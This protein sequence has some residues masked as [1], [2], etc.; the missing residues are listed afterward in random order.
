MNALLPTLDFWGEP[1]LASLWRASWQGSLAIFVAWFVIHWCKFL[2]PRVT[3]WIWRFVCFKLI[4]ALFWIEPIAI[5]LLS[6]SSVPASPA[7]AVTTT[8]LHTN[9]PTT[10]AQAEAFDFPSQHSER[11]GRQQTLGSI[12]CALW[13][14]GGL[15]GC[16]VTARQWL[17]LRRLIHSATAPSSDELTVALREEASRLD[18]RRSPELRISLQV[19]SP[20]L[21]GI[22]RPTILLPASAQ[23]ASERPTLRIMLAH[24]IAHLKRHDLTWNWLP[25]AVGWLFFFHPLVWVMLR[26]WS[27]AQE[28]ACDELLIQRRVAT[29]ADYGR[30]LLHLTNR[31]KVEPHSTLVAAGVLGAYRNLERRILTMSYVRSTSPRRLALVACILAIAAVP[32]LVPWRLVAQESKAPA[33]VGATAAD[34][35]PLSGLIYADA[36]WETETAAGTTEE[37]RGIIAIDPNSGAFKNLGVQG[38]D[39]RVS[40]NRKKFLVQQPSNKE[41]ANRKY[42]H[43]DLYVAGLSD[44]KPVK[45]ADDAGSPVWSP[46]GESILYNV[47]NR[48]DEFGFLSSAWTIDLDSK[49]T[50]KIVVPETDEV[51]D[52]SSQ[53]N[54]LVTVSDRHPPFGHGYQL[55]VMHPDGTGERRLTEGKGLNCYPRFRPDGKQIVY[56]HQEKAIN[57][58]WVVDIDGTN[59]K[60]LLAED[61]AKARPDGACWSPDGKWLAVRK[62]DWQVDE[63]GKKHLGDSRK[64]N[65]RIA[66]HSADGKERCELAIQG[67]K[68]LIS[69]GF[70]DWQ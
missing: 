56:N 32:S 70:P 10:H 16:A 27:E 51:D 15:F 62:C 2:S 7:S 54:W 65:F 53:G 33:A 47:S 8:V 64:A 61:G 6:E 59:R 40:P 36:H 1:W 25:T 38:H 66:I 14:A 5:P 69:V 57:S 11:P 35:E 50:H 29:A 23:N 34:Q 43:Y 21:A 44:P 67:I 4:F 18:V 22:W 63:N 28:A 37:F 19:R 30:F 13:A 24:E 3:C 55:Y 12:L 31:Q 49:Q 39:C 9:T 60:Q 26:R 48:S 52:W 68:Q 17:T 20:L 45:L 46:D 58:L 41:R 42:A